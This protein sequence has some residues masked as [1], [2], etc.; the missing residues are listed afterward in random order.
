V[1][2]IANLKSAAGA[3]VQSYEAAG[4]MG[5]FFGIGIAFA[6]AAAVIWVAQI[7]GAIIASLIFAAIFC[8]AGLIMMLISGSK[9][10]EAETRLKSA[11]QGPVNAARAV[12]SAFS[13]SAQAGSG[14]VLSSALVFVL[15]A[16][17]LYLG[18]SKTSAHSEA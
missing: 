13:P 5:L 7:F 3:F 9:E 11:T 10:K 14:A 2:I 6:L 17:A 16:T 15:L 4:L 12:S 8:I 18:T 1:R